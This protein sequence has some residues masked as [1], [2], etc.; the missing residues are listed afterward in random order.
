MATPKS[1]ASCDAERI[2]QALA[3]GPFSQSRQITARFGSARLPE[4]RL[5]ASEALIRA[6]EAALDAATRD[7]KNRVASDEP[8]LTGAPAP[9][10]EPHASPALGLSP[11][12][13]TQSRASTLPRVLPPRLR[14]DMTGE[15]RMA[16]DGL[17]GG[18]GFLSA[19]TV[20]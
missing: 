12:V 10:D 18:D 1:G 9:Q 11:C 17:S 6:A 16:R 4:D 2:R 5:A 19:S 20:W 14:Q 15:H 13:P 3:D 7:G 8:E